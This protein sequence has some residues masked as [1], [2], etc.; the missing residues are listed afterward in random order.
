MTRA[1]ATLL[2]LAA[3]LLA[4]TLLPPR[5]PEGPLIRTRL[6]MGTVVEIRIEDTESARYDAAVTA[7]FAEMAAIERR[8]S[9]HLPQSEISRIAAATGTVG[10]SADTAEVLQLAHDV[11]EA[12]NGA[13]DATLGQLIRLWGFAEGEPRLPTEEEI[14]AALAGDGASRLMIADGRVA[15][16]VAPLA[17]DLGGIAKGY[18]IDRAVSV[19]AAAGVRHASVNAGGDMRLLGD[20]SGRPWRVGIRHPR[21]SG[22]ILATL[23]LA[24]KAV[25]TS[26]D[27]ERVFELDGVRYHH[28]LDPRTGYPARGC[29]AVT[30]VADRAALADAVAT[31][32]F[33]LG[34]GKGLALLE[35]MPDL[36]GVIVAADGN[37]SVTP[38]LR[39]VLEWP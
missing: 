32:V 9:P 25:V 10:L 20:R 11:A 36:E 37:V 21:K 39:G 22:D 38:G 30:V 16:V 27:Y 14:A 4:I 17:I 8:M 29:Q 12:S 28:I 19:L 2:L 6:L 26:G 3:L 23:Q 15:K 31:A 5:E 33:V 24:G 35:S 1:T 34:P 13:F 7:A 18:A